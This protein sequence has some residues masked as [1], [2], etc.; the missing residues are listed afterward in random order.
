MRKYTYLFGLIFLLFLLIC[1]MQID[2][3]NNKIESFIVDFGTPPETTSTDQGHIK[4]LLEIGSQ[5]HENTSFD[6]VSTQY[7]GDIHRP[8]VAPPPPP[9]P[10]PVCFTE[11]S[12]PNRYIPTDLESY[13]KNCCG[14]TQAT[15]QG[16]DEDEDDDDDYQD[17]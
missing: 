2:N 17:N 14:V 15:Y 4:G 9:P 3:S 6:T 5:A 16:I 11:E 8:T 7:L 13:S 1:L 10:D 12:N